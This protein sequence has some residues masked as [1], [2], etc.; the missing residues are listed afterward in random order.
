MNTLVVTYIESTCTTPPTASAHE[1]LLSSGLRLFSEEGYRGATTRR[2]AED[3]GVSE[4]TLFRHFGTKAGLFEEVLRQRSFLPRLRD[5][6]TDVDGL[7]AGE[8][9]RRIGARY[10]ETLGERRE[11]VKIMLAEV[12]TYPPDVRD[13]H[14]A[15]VRAMDESLAGHLAALQRRGQLRSFP[16]STAARGFLRMLFAY[17]AVEEIIMGRRIARGHRERIVAEFVDLFLNGAASRPGGAR[18]AAVLR[19]GKP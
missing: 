9:L 7:P 12:H 16:A 15:F 3:A 2:I 17:F 1:R 11:L 5:L 13:A 10:L 8:G 14:T 18:P 6:V 19:R 4:L